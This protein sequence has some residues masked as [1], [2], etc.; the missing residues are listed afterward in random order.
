MIE[1]G[2]GRGAAASHRRPP[3]R[4]RDLADRVARRDDRTGGEIQREVSKGA[5]QRC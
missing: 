3:G 1:A 5:E 4:G 2:A